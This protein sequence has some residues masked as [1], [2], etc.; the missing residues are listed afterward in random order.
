[1][2]G[3][4]VCIRGEAKDREEKRGKD[5]DQREGGGWREVVKPVMRGQDKEER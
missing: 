4:V 2:E 5:R 3:K 1:M